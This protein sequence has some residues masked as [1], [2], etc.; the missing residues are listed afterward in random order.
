MNKKAIRVEIAC[1]ILLGATIIVY[2]I[3]S[4]FFS[5]SERSK[6]SK[7]TVF[8]FDLSTDMSSTEVEPGDSFDVRPIVYS[9]TT[10]EMY[11]F[12]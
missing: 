9:D 2:A 10:E 5:D 8:Q 7:R 4:L 11:V 1:G 3:T 12:I 6:L